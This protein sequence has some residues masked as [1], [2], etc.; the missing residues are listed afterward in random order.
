MNLSNLS[1]TPCIYVIL[2]HLRAFYGCVMYMKSQVVVRDIQYSM[3]AV[4]REDV[5]FQ[6][7]QMVVGTNLVVMGLKRIWPPSLLGHGTRFGTLVSLNVLLAQRTVV[8]F[9][10]VFCVE[11]RC[12]L[13]P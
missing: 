7:M 1:R 6:S 10:S 13:L 2:I 5:L 12:R 4:C 11:G 9:G 8:R 3:C